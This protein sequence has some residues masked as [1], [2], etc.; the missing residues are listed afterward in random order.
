MQRK[1]SRHKAFAPDPDAPAQCCDHP[2]CDQPAGYRAPRGR[3]NLRSY[4]WFCLEH[5][6]QYNASW[7]YYRGMTPG[8]IEQHLREDT[9]WQRP[10]WKMGTPGHDSAR[11]SFTL[12]DLHDPLDILKGHRTR[13]SREAETRRHAPAALRE[14]LAQLDL[15]WPTTIEVIKTR[16]RVLA[17]RYHPDANQDDPRAEERFKVIG[18]AYATLRNHFANST[19][20]ET[21]EAG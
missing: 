12:D 1:P 15:E 14:P 18:T 2:D 16:Y 4:Y 7:D 11:A 3:D 17:R 6:R 19:E 8:Q 20:Q 10:S 9:S 5:V 21:A 13:P